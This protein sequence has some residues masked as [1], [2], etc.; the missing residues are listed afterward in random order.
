MTQGNLSSS[1]SFL[2]SR[3]DK[4]MAATRWWWLEQMG[5]HPSPPLLLP[6]SWHRVGPPQGWLAHL[7]PPEAACVSEVPRGL[8]LA[9]MAT[10]SAALS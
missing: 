4:L 10:T 3:A 5:H 9:R 7:F 2:G 1:S 6:T 8:L